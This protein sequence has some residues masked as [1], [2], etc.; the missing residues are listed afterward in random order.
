MSMDRISVPETDEAGGVFAI[1]SGEFNERQVD[2][3]L[4]NHGGTLQ[5]ACD[6]YQAGQLIYAGDWFR[7]EFV[8]ISESGENIQFSDL[9]GGGEMAIEDWIDS[10]AKGYLEDELGEIWNDVKEMYDDQ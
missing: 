6:Y 1:V 5:N 10:V 2:W 8:G 9:H 4:R 3:K 7:F